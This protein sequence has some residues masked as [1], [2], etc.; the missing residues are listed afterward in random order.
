MNSNNTHLFAM[1]ILGVLA[2]ALFASNPSLNSIVAQVISQSCFD[3]P[4]HSYQNYWKIKTASK[5]KT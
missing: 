1:C 5:E 4:Y 3:F 2:S